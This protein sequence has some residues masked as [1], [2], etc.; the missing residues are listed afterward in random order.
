[1]L[2]SG[3]ESRRS[4][5][6]IAIMA[7]AFIAMALCIIGQAS[8][9]ESIF[10]DGFVYDTDGVTPVTAI[11]IVYY[12]A[13]PSGIA[14]QTFMD[15]YWPYG[16]YIIKGTRSGGI[17]TMY[18]YTYSAD[19]SRMDRKSPEAVFSLD[20]VSNGSYLTRNL[21]LQAL[22]PTPVPTMTSM[23]ITTPTPTPNPAPATAV[24]IVPGNSV[25]T[26]SPSPTPAVY[27]TPGATPGNNDIPSTG[28]NIDLS[29]SGIM[30]TA[31]MIVGGVIVMLLVLYCLAIL[32]V[33][34][35]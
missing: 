8:A 14:T 21:T 31:A 5:L 12:P 34:K 32:I 24:T 19:H 20:S 10:F 15:G 29:V 17:A 4:W 33:T 27:A 18:A 16:Y 35:L 11:V 28:G 26:V 3:R 1:M 30:K 6:R 25:V 13:Y 2:S 23:P 9:E 7:S 22:S